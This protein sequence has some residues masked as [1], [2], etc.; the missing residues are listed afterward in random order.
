MCRRQFVAVTVSMDTWQIHGCP[1]L[2]S[3]LLHREQMLLLPQSESWAFSIS[4]LPLCF[5]LFS[6][7]V[8]PALLFHVHRA[9]STLLFSTPA[10]GAAVDGTTHHRSFQLSRCLLD[11]TSNSDV[12]PN[13]ARVQQPPKTLD[14]QRKNPCSPT[15]KKKTAG[16][17]YRGCRTRPCRTDGGNTVEGTK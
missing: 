17:S 11:R 5:P 1:C 7:F 15:Y 6:C 14:S 16:P 2:S 13:T 9:G 4:P 12:P 3:R 8:V 10:A